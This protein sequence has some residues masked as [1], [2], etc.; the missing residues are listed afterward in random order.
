MGR[1]L[2]FTVQMSK[3]RLRKRR[4]PRIP[5]AQKMAGFVAH[6]PKL[7]KS[8][9]ITFGTYWSHPENWM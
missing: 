1:R 8:A 7:A 5:D 3:M 2:N 9:A 4:E 6:R